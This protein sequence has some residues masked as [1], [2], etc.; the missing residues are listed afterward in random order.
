MKSAPELHW[1]VTECFTDDEVDP[2]FYL[3]LVPPLPSKNFRGERVGNVEESERMPLLELCV[4]AAEEGIR[5]SAAL[6]HSTGLGTGMTG[7][8]IADGRDPEEAMINGVRELQRLAPVLHLGD[9]EKLARAA[10]EPVHQ[11]LWCTG[12]K[13]FGRFVVASGST[14]ARAYIAQAEALDPAELRCPLICPVPP[15]SAGLVV[16]KPVNRFCFGYAPNEI[17]EECAGVMETLLAAKAYKAEERME[18]LRQG[19]Q[20][21]GVRYVTRPRRNRTRAGSAHPTTDRN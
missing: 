4:D 21:I 8:D 10:S 1:E 2:G 18:L 12:L 3:T 13:G 6:M 7:Q 19:L 16:G 11:L 14:S 15:G 20:K 9:A 5:W 17:V